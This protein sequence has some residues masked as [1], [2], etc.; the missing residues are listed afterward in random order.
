[1][2]TVCTD[3][4]QQSRKVNSKVAHCITGHIIRPRDELANAPQF[5]VC[6]GSD[7]TV[8]V[9]DTTPGTPS[10]TIKEG[11]IVT[12]GSTMVSGTNLLSIGKYNSVSEDGKDVD[13]MSIVPKG[14]DD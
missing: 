11:S 10:T 1:V 14:V 2:E 7:F 4:G 8:R 13:K 12:N 5:L 3:G 6:A 9:F